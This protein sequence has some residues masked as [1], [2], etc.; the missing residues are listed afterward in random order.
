MNILPSPSVPPGRT[1]F[2]GGTPCQDPANIAPTRPSASFDP[3]TCPRPR[4]AS[5][6]ATTGGAPARGVV[7][8]PPAT[9]S[10][11]APSTTWV[12]PS[13]PARP[14]ASSRPCPHPYARRCRKYF[15][16]AASELADPGSHYPRRVVDTAVRLVVEDGLPYRSAAWALWRDHRVFVPYATIQNWVE[17]GGETGGPADRH[18]PSQ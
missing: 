6:A 4:S 18:R 5:A 12:I 8:A 15:N 17:A 10:S 14:P 3:R 16:A 7:T 11:A 2:S 9:G 13:P 1:V